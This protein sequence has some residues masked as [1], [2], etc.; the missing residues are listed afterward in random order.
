MELDNIYE[1]ME[2][3]KSSGL[4][5]LELRKADLLIKME[6]PRKTESVQLHNTSVPMIGES[7]V[8]NRPDERNVPTSE[9]KGKY[10]RS[11][12]VGIFYAAPE[13]GAAPYVKTGDRVQ[14]G[15]AVCI[16]EA[17]KMM[18]EINYIDFIVLLL[19][20]SNQDILLQRMLKEYLALR[21]VRP[22]GG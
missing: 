8:Q 2:K 10:I 9:A 12:I 17:M 4:A 18:N 13:E 16:V 3:F 15:T 6:M 21:K 7:G 22:L 14:K 19:K 11:P 5:K 1:L 20:P